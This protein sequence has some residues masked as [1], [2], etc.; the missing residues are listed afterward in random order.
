VSTKSARERLEKSTGD[1]DSTDCSTVDRKHRQDALM[2]RGCRPVMVHVHGRLEASMVWN[3]M[4]KVQIVDFRH[5]H[6]CVFVDG[7]RRRGG[8]CG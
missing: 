2:I 7:L 8:C 4:W 6:T 5:K 1:F 3:V